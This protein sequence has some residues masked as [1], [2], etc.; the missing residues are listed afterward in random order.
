MR[1]HGRQCAVNLE[2]CLLMFLL[3]NVFCEIIK[4]TNVQYVAECFLC[5]FGG[6]GKGERAR[7]A[8]GGGERGKGE[9]VRRARGGGE[10]GKGE[11]GGDSG[12]RGVRGTERLVEG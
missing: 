6:V 7:R 1:T 9:R 8:R 2:L 5:L 11:K 3:G 4:T 12:G 10:R